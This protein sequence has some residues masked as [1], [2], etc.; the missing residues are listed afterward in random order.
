MARKIRSSFATLF[1]LV[2]SFLTTGAAADGFGGIYQWH[3]WFG[4]AGEEPVVGDFD[5]DDLDD[6]AVVAADGTVY[7]ALSTGDHLE[8]TAVVWGHGFPV[9][10]VAKTGDVDGDGRDDL[11][12]FIRDS[13]MTSERGD[14]YVMRALASSGFGA[15]V[16]WH[17]WFGIGE[18]RPEVIDLNDDTRADLVAFSPDG[19]VWVAF[20]T[21][22]GF[23]GTSVS[24]RSGF[25]TAGE[26]VLVGDFNGDRRGDI[27]MVVRDTLPFPGYGDVYV[28]KNTGSGFA[29]P[30]KW[31]ES[32]CIGAWGPEVPLAGDFNGDGL[33][34]I[35]C[36]QNPPV[37][38]LGGRVQVALSNFWTPRFDD[39]VIWM[40]NFLRSGMLPAVGRFNRDDKHDLAAF[41]RDTF[42]DAR[43][44][45]VWISVADEPSRETG[46]DATVFGFGSERVNGRAAA[47]ERPLLVVYR[48]D[49]EPTQDINHDGVPDIPYG[50]HH[51]LDYYDD[52][53]F[54]T[55]VPNIRD[56]FLENSNDIFTWSKADVVQVVALDPALGIS[57]VAA[58]TSFDFADY[59]ENGDGRVTEDELGVLMFT[60]ESVQEGQTVSDGCVDVGSVDFCGEISNVGQRGGFATIAH[61]LTHQLLDYATD[62]YYNDDEDANAEGNR[63]LSLMAAT[64]I[65][66]DAMDSWHLD[67]WHKMVLGWLE[68][69]VY[70]LRD[71]GTFAKLAPP[72]SPDYFSGDRSPV[73]L[74]DPLSGFERFFLLEHRLQF[75]Y[76]AVV[77]SADGSWNGIALWRIEVDAGRIFHI[78]NPGHPNPQQSTCDIDTEPRCMLSNQHL[79]A[80]NMGSGGGK[81]W[82]PAAFST[83][84]SFVELPWRQ[85]DRTWVKFRVGPLPY[86]TGTVPM[87]AEWGLVKLPAANLEAASGYQV[88]PG[89]PIE[90]SGALGLRRSRP[91]VLEADD[92]TRYPAPVLSWSATRATIEVPEAPAGRYRVRVLDDGITPASGTWVELEMLAVPTID[93]PDE[94]GVDHL[95]DNCSEVANPT[96]VDSDADGYGNACDADYDQNGFVGISDFN[97]FKAA[98][99]TAAGDPDYDEVVDCNADGVIG[100]PDFQ[101]F[102]SQF[103][104]APGPSALVCTPADICSAGPAPT[105]NG[106]CVATVCAADAYCC[107]FEWDSICVSAAETMCGM[108][109]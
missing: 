14:V 70:S 82:T 42:S 97:R 16:R 31:H 47:G 19:D 2:A 23:E 7:V 83:D 76:D 101:C 72:T 5:G 21:G 41:V 44:G 79:G 36:L 45:D 77:G 100:V 34:D 30:E 107:E 106:P 33:D 86:S 80:P 57:M 78:P 62:I 40:G 92:G 89:N 75:G 38:T 20:S 103:G 9:G 8:G 37:S 102:K 46:A 54:G 26:D 66:P 69:R 84:A 59:D 90:L 61:E 87:T 6:T 11:I 93:D 35:A 52:L 98:L 104:G 94:D 4:L 73:L 105:C 67:P 58:A 27:A 39:P 1:V 13:R 109:Q 88:Y 85:G 48:F 15:P 99:G 55:S 91:V 56:F 96:Q 49:P 71:P 60:N 68:P 25:A 22:T 65:G 3:D 32:L 51:P 24:W 108:C 63:L 81:L 53:V 43:Y 95:L 18:E 17:D 29:A 50:I 64:G 74:Y 12:A 10:A 28:A